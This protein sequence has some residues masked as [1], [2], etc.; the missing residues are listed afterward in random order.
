MSERKRVEA[1]I[2][3]LVAERDQIH[4]VIGPMQTRLVAIYEE[5]EPLEEKRDQLRLEDMK[6]PDWKRL[7]KDVASDSTSSL[8]L[9]RYFDK[10]LLEHYGM[11]HSGSW[12]DTHEANIEVMVRRNDLSEKGSICGVEFFAKLMTPH[13]NGRVWFGIFENT[14]SAGG[15]FRLEVLP[16][17]S[18]LYLVVTTYP[19][20]RTLKEFHS[21]KEAIKYIRQHHWYGEEEEARA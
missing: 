2:A 4:T 9:L 20:E 6:K 5:L 18:K 12:S 13:K 7:I 19:R 11:Y 14:L 1:E 17:L 3:K 21:T 8:T 16:D 10:Q 15:I